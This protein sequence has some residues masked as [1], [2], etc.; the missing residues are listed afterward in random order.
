MIRAALFFFAFCVL[1]FALPPL[2][3]QTSFPMV[4]HCT[5]TAV[6]RGTTAEVEVAGQQDFVGAYKVLV[7]GAGVA[8]EVAPAKDAKGPAWSVKLKVTVAPDAELGVREFRI[9]TPLG[10]SSLGQL[11][12]VADPVVAEKPGIN[13]PAKA[14]PVPVPAVVCGRI[15]AAENVDHYKVTA[16]AGRV[17][18]F[19]VFG[20][21]IQDK[22]H[23]LQKHIDPLVRV[24]DAA[25][26]EL[27]ASDDAFF[28]DPLLAF[29]APADG[30]YVVEVRDAK[31]DGDP[32]WAY[33]LAITDR[34]FVAHLY[35][36]GLTRGR[37]TIVEPVLTD[38]DARP[39]WTATTPTQPGI[40]TLTFAP[41][42]ETLNPVPVV[43]T[44][45]PTAREQ[46]PNDT[47]SQATRLA[48]PGGVNGRIQAKRDLDHFTFKAA[49]SKPV[50]LEVFAR[51][52]GTVL[53]SQLDASLDVMTPDGKVLATG[54]D[55]AGKDP[56]LVFTPPADGEFVARVRDLNNKGGDGFVYY[57][58]A[59]LARPDF[60]IKCDP[61]K[62]MIGPGSRTAWYV[63]ITR[64]DG[65]AG[66]VKVTV[67]GLPAGV[68]A[69]PL[70]IPANMTQG[71]LVLS[72][73]AGAKLDASAVE[74]V[75][76]GGGLT[77][78]ATPVEE[79]YFPGGG[80]GRFDVG[81]PAVAV[82][83]PSDLLEV[84]ASVKKVVLKPGQEVKIDVTVKRRKDYDKT[85]TLDVL[86]RHLGQVH[87]TPLPPGVTM[88]DGKSKTLLGSGNAGSIVLKAAADAPACADVP[89]CVQGFVPVNF[90]VK[91]GYA[92]EPILVSVKRD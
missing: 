86:L 35:P 80:R 78:T 32:R 91:I 24:F 41:D 30:E 25:G 53:R 3:A 54:D 77:R 19:E 50:R 62:A 59:D 15:E 73:A 12:V 58:E 45:L 60:T 67:K 82:T 84:T 17:L 38:P 90:V 81:M 2:A 57:L 55:S 87:G 42:S 16:K 11:L 79:I 64:L 37:T 28:A 92:S 36:F 5:P 10:V 69:S 63:Q 1:P 56:V 29:K 18:T 40:Q 14:Q 49:K 7:A 9:A 34:P 31:Y 89:V 39:K 75:G 72:A 88:V 70:T 27:A 20:A 65:F 4:T 71:C 66:P 21:R 33:A 48:V 74:V 76:E 83:G 26:R 6:Q 44:D 52:F 85:V 23:D 47:P 13:T 22:I 46:E 8:A 43:V 61:S 68:T 51:R